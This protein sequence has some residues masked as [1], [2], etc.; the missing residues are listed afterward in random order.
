MKNSLSLGL[1]QT[2]L[3]PGEQSNL[4][5]PVEST[6]VASPGPEQNVPSKTSEG[7]PA[8]PASQTFRAGGASIVYVHAFCAQ[9]L[10]EKSSL[11]LCR[12]E[13]KGNCDIDVL[14]WFK[15]SPSE[16][17][18]MMNALED[19]VTKKFNKKTDF[20]VELNEQVKKKENSIL[21]SRIKNIPSGE[22]GAFKMKSSSIVLFIIP[23]TAALLFLSLK[24]FR[25][26]REKW[27]RKRRLDLLLEGNFI[28]KK[29]SHLQR[30][31]QFPVSSSHV[32]SSGV[33]DRTRRL[34]EDD[35]SLEPDTSTEC[36]LF[37]ILELIVEETVVIVTD[38]DPH[39]NIYVSA[40]FEVTKSEVY[41]VGCR[42]RCQ[43]EKSMQNSPIILLAFLY[44]LLPLN[45]TFFNILLSLFIIFYLRHSQSDIC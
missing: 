22:R 43:Y 20:I 30:M 34:E 42:G 4:S 36:E 1:P 41:V 35:F 10:G 13:M 27:E 14:S 40:Q 9:L 37:D 26:F 11:E 2:W 12:T 25:Y 7:P 6:T 38:S 31:I 17:S 18:N 16:S 8:G 19:C 39:L 21:Q 23:S 3:S 28:D 24:T 32:M 45:H 33:D 5:E 15:L 29:F 44:E